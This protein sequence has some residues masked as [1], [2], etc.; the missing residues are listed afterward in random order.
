MS[1]YRD[2][3]YGA[4]VNVTSFYGSLQG[5]SQFM[6][7]IET[8]GCT[9]VIVTIDGFGGNYWNNGRCRP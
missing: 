9:F 1:A 7:G 3:L 4:R 2:R 6:M 5:H 8:A